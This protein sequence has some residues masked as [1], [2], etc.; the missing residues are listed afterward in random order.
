MK[1]LINDESGIAW[2]LVVVFILMVGGAALYLF[3]SPSM[4]GLIDGFNLPYV[5]STA[6]ARTGDAAAFGVNVWLFLPIITI[7]GLF[8]WLISRAHERGE[9]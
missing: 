4:N 5:Q 9:E 3:M 6:T 1:N 2:G 8:A 7:F